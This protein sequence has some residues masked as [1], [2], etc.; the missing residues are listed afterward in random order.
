MQAVN[1]PEMKERV[2]GCPVSLHF[3]SKPVDGVMDAVRSILSNA[4]NERMQKELRE[5]MD[6]GRG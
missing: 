2:N 3:P 5:F 1:T 4:Y 6:E